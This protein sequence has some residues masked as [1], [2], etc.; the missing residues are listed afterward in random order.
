MNSKDL[1]KL[2]NRRLKMAKETLILKNAVYA[3]TSDRLS[4]FKTGASFLNI[5]P[6]KT[7]FSYLT[8]HLSALHEFVLR[9]DDNNLTELAEWQ[10]KISDSINYLIFLEALVTE[11]TFRTHSKPESFTPSTFPEAET[12]D[13]PK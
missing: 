12:P 13:D 1:T 11:R 6:E 10:E 2:V 3:R 5:T 8:K 7:L 4:N 9:L